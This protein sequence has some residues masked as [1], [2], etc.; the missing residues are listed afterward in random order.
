M[1]AVAA[2]RNHFFF[3]TLI[4]RDLPSAQAGQAIPPDWS[5]EFSL[6]ERSMLRVMAGET[7]FL[8]PLLEDVRKNARDIR[9]LQ[10]ESNSTP[11]WIRKLQ[12]PLFEPQDTLNVFAD[13]YLRL[14]EAFAVP[15]TQY[16]QVREHWK[17]TCHQARKKVDFY[18]FIGALVMRPVDCTSFVNYPFRT[19]SVEGMRRAAL[20]AARMHARG[21]TPEAAAA[22]VAASDLRDPYTGEPFEWNPERSS[23]TFD[24]T[25]DTRWPRVEFFY[26]AAPAR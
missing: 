23:V 14:S 8:K 16:A 22:E 3:S 7:M 18:N 4:L 13:E 26:R 25:E 6:E 5:R 24:G 20:L 12:A 15:M 10:G 11:N 2:L 17:A 9:D 21:L 1:I 19:A